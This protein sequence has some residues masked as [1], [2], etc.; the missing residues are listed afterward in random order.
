VHLL[1]AAVTV[2][3]L[4]PSLDVHL[5]REVDEIRQALQA[6]PWNRFFSLP[7]SHELLHFRMS[8]VHGTMAAHA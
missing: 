5:V 6:H 7:L 8:G 3:A 2:S 4:H 1:D